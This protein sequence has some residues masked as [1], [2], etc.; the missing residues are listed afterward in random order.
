VK[1]TKSQE[2]IAAAQQIA[3]ALVGELS[4]RKGW[5]ARELEFDLPHKADEQY[6]LI[7]VVSFGERIDFA[8]WIDRTRSRLRDDVPL[9]CA[10]FGVDGKKD[11]DWLTHLAKSEGVR[12]QPYYYVPEDRLIGFDHQPVLEEPSNVGRFLSSY[13]AAG[14]YEVVPAIRQFRRFWD[15]WAAKV[16]PLAHA[17]RRAKR[18]RP[19]WIGRAARGV[20]GELAVLAQPA[21]S[22]ATWV[23]MHTEPYDIQNGRDLIEV[24]T[25]AD[26]TVTMSRGQ[27]EAGENDRYFV[28]IVELPP[29]A[30]LALSGAIDGDKKLHPIVAR[31]KE[32]ILE[33]LRR[34][35]VTADTALYA[36]ISCAVRLSMDAV[37]MHRLE[38]PAGFY[39]ALDAV[40]QFGRISDFSI[41]CGYDW[42][43]PADI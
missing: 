18:L 30:R 32:E 6:G 31:Y 20:V 24:K 38:P 27:I 3:A 36:A 2:A 7:N 1:T 33:Y 43:K 5:H 28:A 39:D 14:R 34:R 15:L 13:R 29:D 42:F 11:C 12:R 35:G 16:E 25:R 8:I 23:G 4:L 26:E 19:D 40:E 37:T 9:L 10:A 17:P 22:K 41:A 21:C